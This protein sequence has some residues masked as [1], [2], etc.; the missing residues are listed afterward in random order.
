MEVEVLE[1]F[2]AGFFASPLI[3]CLL[4]RLTQKQF[5]FAAHG[6]SPIPT[7][8]CATNKGVTK[9]VRLGSALLHCRTVSLR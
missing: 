5:S 9:C 8:R 6:F 2:S 7:M 3:K 1:T 4:K